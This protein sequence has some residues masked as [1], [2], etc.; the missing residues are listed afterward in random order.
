MTCDSNWYSRTKLFYQ[1]LKSHCPSTHLLNNILYLNDNVASVQVM[2]VHGEGG[3]EVL[4]YL[5]T[6][7]TS[8]L[9]ESVCSA[10]SPDRLLRCKSRD[11]IEVG[12]GWEPD[13][14]WRL[15][16]RQK[17]IGIFRNPTTVP[18][19]HGL[20]TNLYTDSVIWA[21]DIELKPV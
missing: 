20:Y 3:I 18:Q 9:Q 16:R 15:W 2:K 8:T 1:L 11:T 7:L 21:P 4:L 6:I 5:H 17:P 13:V 10:S 14:F 12:A 19:M